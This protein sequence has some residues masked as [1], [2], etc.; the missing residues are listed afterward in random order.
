V[1]EH[2]ILFQYLKQILE[3]CGVPVVHAGRRDDIPVLF[4]SDVRVRILATL[5]ATDSAEY[6]YGIEQIN[7]LSKKRL[8]DGSDRSAIEFSAA[9][10]SIALSA[11]SASVA[12]SELPDPNQS[13]DASVSTG[14]VAADR[15]LSNFLVN[16]RHVQ[17]DGEKHREQTHSDESPRGQPDTTEIAVA[18][19]QAVVEATKQ[20]NHDK[21]LG[22]RIRETTTIIAQ[23]KDDTFSGE[24]SKNFMDYQERYETVCDN[25]SVSQERRLE[26]FLYVVSGGARETFKKVVQPHA[27]FFAELIVGMR[28]IYM[29]ADRRQRA[30]SEVSLITLAKLVDPKD[31]APWDHDA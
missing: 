2:R 20:K 22:D 31:A 12:A 29:S 18:I 6:I 8:Y 21:P 17:T 7:I 15:V 13:L 4:R 1:I 10:K 3:L 25:I 5:F 9:H 23:F 11:A 16:D 26:L 28:Q 30:L 19:A 14:T 24:L 27:T